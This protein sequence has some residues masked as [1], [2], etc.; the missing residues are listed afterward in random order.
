MQKVDSAGGFIPV[1]VFHVPVLDVGTGRFVFVGYLPDQAALEIVYLYRYLR[2]GEQVVNNRGARGN[3][4]ILRRNI[5]IIINASALFTDG[6]SNGFRSTHDFGPLGRIVF[7]LYANFDL[8][9]GGIIPQEGRKYAERTCY[10][11]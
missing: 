11:A 2:R 5:K 1:F 8:P 6:K 9:H 7:N 4:I 10:V 3:R